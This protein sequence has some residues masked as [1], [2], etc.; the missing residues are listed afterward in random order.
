MAYALYWQGMKKHITAWIAVLILLFGTYI[1]GHIGYQRVQSHSTARAGQSA[2]KTSASQPAGFNKKQYSLDDPASLWVVVN[3]Q[4]PLNPKTYAP[5]DLTDIGNGQRMRLAAAN[6]LKL[7]FSAA[8]AAGYTLVAESGYRSYGTQ[9]S[10]YNSEVRAFGQAKADSESARPGYSEHQTGWAVDIG[11]P[12]CYEDCFGTKPASKWL[13]TVAYKY[14]FI[15]RYPPDKT[16]ITGYREEPW[17]FRYIGVDLA[18]ELHKQ[19][20]ETLEE[21]FGL[22]AAPNY[23]P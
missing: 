15:R 14:G 17:H 21:F 4:R 12:G 19:N 11:S 8:K 5:S 2:A 6:Q 10:V 20:V 18:T 23:S 1:V 3:K 9:V 13:L 7:L 16:D 22:P